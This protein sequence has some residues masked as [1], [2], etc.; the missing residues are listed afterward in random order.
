MHLLN[1]TKCKLSLTFFQ[2]QRGHTAMG[3]I[4]G[5]TLHNHNSDNGSSKFNDLAELSPE[6]AVQIMSKLQALFEDTVLKNVTL[7]VPFLSPFISHGSYLWIFLIKS[8]F[9]IFGCMIF[10]ISITLVFIFYSMLLFIQI[11]LKITK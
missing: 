7:K 6:L 11:C 8:R 4:F 10:G 2:T 3:R 9:S 1:P 5:G